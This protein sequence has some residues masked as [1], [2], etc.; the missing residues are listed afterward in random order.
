MDWHARGKKIKQKLINLKR[1][2]SCRGGVVCIEQIGFDWVE[3]QRT[4]WRV[5]VSTLQS[6]HRGTDRLHVTA[7]GG[8]VWRG[9]HMWNEQMI[10]KP[11]IKIK[12]LIKANCQFKES[13]E[14]IQLAR[15]SWSLHLWVTAGGGHGAPAA[16]IALEEDHFLL[17]QKK[18]HFIFIFKIEV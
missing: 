7:G 16:G 6:I 15:C 5:L 8:A 10:F 1:G 14:S 18:I 11:L 13:G 3:G 17:L 2:G 4:F 9:C 12:A